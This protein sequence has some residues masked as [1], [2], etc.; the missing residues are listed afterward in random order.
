MSAPI[1]KLLGNAIK[2]LG[3]ADPSVVRLEEN[4]PQMGNAVLLLGL[5]QG[6]VIFVAI[7]GQHDT[8]GALEQILDVV[9]GHGAVSPLAKVEE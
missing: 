2:I 6:G 5:G 9:G 4:C 3:P 8:I 7:V 1:T